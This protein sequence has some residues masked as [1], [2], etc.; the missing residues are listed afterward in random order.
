MK[1]SALTLAACLAAGLT[2]NAAAAD[3]KGVSAK[4]VAV[5]FGELTG[6][7]TITSNYIF[8]GIS[9]SNNLPA[10]QGGLTYT[11][12]STG[13]YFNLWG[14]NVNFADPQDNTATVEIDTIVGISNPI[15][16]HFTYNV[17]F[18][19]YNYPKS[20]AS[21]SE[22]IASAQWY[23]L[24]GQIAYS[25]NVYG[26]HKSGTY[27]NVGFK[28]DVPAEYL[29]KVDNVS[30]AGGVGHYSMPRSAGLSSYNDYNLGVSKTIG[31]YV[32]AVQWTDTGGSSFNLDS[33][34]TAPTRGSHFTGSV[35]VNF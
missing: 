12:P 13:I 26:Y 10:F 32:L 31:N 6:N 7:F 15:G 28:Y 4:P 14:S 18:N 22:A 21:Y 27:Y 8:R 5:P 3:Y 11:L 35:T 29:F 30:V 1:K 20:A 23:F 2:L 33:D 24:T 34:P 17:N 19:R 25:S 16:D 9:N